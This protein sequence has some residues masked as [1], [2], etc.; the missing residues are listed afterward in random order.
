MPAT[1]QQV[2]DVIKLRNPSFEDVPRA[3]GMG[4]Y[5]P[6]GWK[7]LSQQLQT[8]VDIQPGFFDV[9]KK[10]VNGVSYLGMVTRSDESWEAVSQRLESPLIAGQCYTFTA[11]LA[12]SPEYISHVRNSISKENFA[13]PVKLRIHGSNNLGEAKEL[14]DESP[15]VAHSEWKK[16]TFRFEP[17]INHSYIRLEVFFRNPVLFPYNGNILVDNLGAIVII[18]CDDEI[19][20]DEVIPPPIVDMVK[21]KKDREQSKYSMYNFEANILNVNSKNELTVSL[22]NRSI[23]FQYS[24]S[25]QTVKAN[26]NLVEGDNK[27]KITAKT[28]GG[29]SSESRIIVFNPPP[30]LAEEPVAPAKPFNPQIL[31]ELKDKESLVVGKSI[32][33]DKLT[34]AADSSKISRA[35]YPVLN[36]LVDFLKANE[37]I[38]IEIGGHTNNRCQDSFCNRLSEKRAKSVVDYLVSRGVPEFR[39]GFKGYG[40]TKPI[41]TNNTPTG[42]RTNQRVE[43]KVTKIA[44]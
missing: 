1:A 16:Y 29:T 22:R 25:N 18:N 26:L 14:L 33:I 21:P 12:R 39:L 6:G 4:G 13:N 28:Q 37:D 8:S 17:R 7:D 32:P 31:K 2:G 44:G 19:K 36:E 11:Y 23:P 30:K 34:F 38:S 15:L 3:G 40:R 24:A 5:A 9:V 35:N 10:P 41:A 42:R 27:I 20:E 43:I